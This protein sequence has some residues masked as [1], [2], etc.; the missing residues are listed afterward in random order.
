MTSLRCRR[1]PLGDL[2]ARPQRLRRGCACVEQARADPE[3]YW[4]FRAVFERAVK[5]E[6]AMELCYSR[7]AG[8]A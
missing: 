8:V 7:V 1:T 2:P 6:D 5:I 4:R 3:R